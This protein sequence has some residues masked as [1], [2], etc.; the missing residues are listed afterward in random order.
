[1]KVHIV[2]ISFSSSESLVLGLVHPITDLTPLFYPPG[3]RLREVSFFLPPRTVSFVNIILL[4]NYFPKIHLI[5]LA[6][7]YLRN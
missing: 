7:L 1:M 6:L 2:L 3:C 4:S 5:S